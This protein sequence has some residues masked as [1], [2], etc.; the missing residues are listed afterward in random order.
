MKTGTIAR[1]KNFTKEREWDQ[2]HSPVNLAKSIVIEAAELLEIFQW[3]ENLK[4]VSLVKDELAD[5]LIYCTLLAEKCGLD[6][7]EIVNDKITKNHEKYPVSKSKG[8]SKK[9]NEFDK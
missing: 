9:Y 5:I 7:E 4:D 1:I 3:S 6:I 2:F 8:S